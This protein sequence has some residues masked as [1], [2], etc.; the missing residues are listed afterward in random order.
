[1][2]D[3]RAN[4][5]LLG[6]RALP[7][8]LTDGAGGGKGC[9]PRLPCQLIAG[10][11]KTMTAEFLPHQ[12][13]QPMPRLSKTGPRPFARALKPIAMPVDLCNQHVDARCRISRL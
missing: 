12:F 6:R 8:G 7:Q 4:A 10:L 3:F 9:V 13:V 11:G 2:P 1:M 5:R